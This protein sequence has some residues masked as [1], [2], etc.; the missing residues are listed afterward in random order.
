ME[1]IY[2]DT[3]GFLMSFD[4]EGLNDISQVKEAILYIKKPSGLVVS[5]TMTTIDNELAYVTVDGDLNEEGTYYLQVYII[6]KDDRY[7]GYV[8]KV[9]MQ[10]KGALK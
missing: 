2:V 8:S 9:S 4:I 1:D 6:L 5:R 7:K 10:V 3:V